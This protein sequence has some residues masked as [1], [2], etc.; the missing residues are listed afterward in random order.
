MN[1]IDILE[2]RLALAAC[3]DVRISLAEL[4]NNRWSWVYRG[5]T[6]IKAY[7]RTHMTFFTPG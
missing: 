7:T 6:C 3:K 1:H 4:R 5:P 2:N